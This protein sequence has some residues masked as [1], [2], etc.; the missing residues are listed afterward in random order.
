M[1]FACLTKYYIFICKPLII[2]MVFFF[3]YYMVN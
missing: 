1:P 2:R 3:E